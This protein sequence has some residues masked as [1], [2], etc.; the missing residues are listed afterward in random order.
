MECIMKKV[1]VFLSGDTHGV[2]RSD[3]VRDLSAAH[4]DLEF[5]DPKTLA[6]RD[7]R[8][9]AL[10]EREWLDQ[11][12]CLFFFF[13]ASNPSGIGSAFEVGYCIAKGI[14]VVFVDDKRTSHSEW[15]GIHCNRVEYSLTAGIEAL[16]ETISLIRST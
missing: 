4:A 3:V 5:F 15:L 9:I 10:I 16:S 14:P 12:D 1:R 11:S 13:A 8:S 7:M 2:W 6:G